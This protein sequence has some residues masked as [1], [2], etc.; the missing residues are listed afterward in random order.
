MATPAVR[1]RTSEGIGPAPRGLLGPFSLAYLLGLLL[2]VA[3][4]YNG[5]VWNVLANTRLLSPLIKGGFI[6]LTDQ[7]EGLLVPNGIPDLTYY[8]KAVDPVD[9]GL[10]A[11]A[12]AVFV[13]IWALKAIQFHGLARY[14]G[15]T[16]SFGQ[17]ARAH[18]YGHGLNRVFPYRVG[19]VATA[20]ALEGQGVPLERA[21][22]VVYVAGAFVVFEIFVFAIIG[23]FYS[24]FTTWL[25]ELFWPV[26]ML[27]VAYL[28]TRRGRSRA[29]HRERRRRAVAD[30]RQ[31]LLALAQRPALLARLAALSLAAFF[32]V[33][34]SAYMVAQSFTSATVILNVDFSVILMGVV[35]GYIARLIP[36]TPGGIGQWEWGFAIPLY[37]GGLGFPEAVTLPLLV[38][39]LRY[40]TGGLVFAVVTM[41]YGVETNLGRVFGLFRRSAGDE[42]AA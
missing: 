17:H 8:Q 9:W 37:V 40:L 34:L 15:L 5:G 27:G 4:I 20:S 30:A 24:G 42:A 29:E 22:Q 33:E 1:R 3:L 36:V 25:T 14:A 19:D 26:V 39:T 35:G 16:G 6:A 18:F 38:T 23:L 12:A 11:L 10:L 21:A 28:I 7:D 2:L 31:A 13:L 32:L 41:L